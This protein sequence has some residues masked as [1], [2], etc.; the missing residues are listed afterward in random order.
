M[1]MRDKRRAKRIEGE[2]TLD[3]PQN[4]N[5]AEFEMLTAENCCA[6][7]VDHQPGLYLNVSDISMVALRNNSI[8]LAKVLKLHNIPTVIS[9]A[10]QG[11]IG[12]MGPF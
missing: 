6:L 2:H 11:P 4:Q 3:K 5:F 8:A 9:C 1:Q 10:A 12:P 7:L